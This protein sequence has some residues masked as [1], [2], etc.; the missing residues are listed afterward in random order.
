M[1]QQARSLPTESRSCQSI[2]WNW[3]DQEVQ[4][5]VVG[6]IEMALEQL[7]REQLQAAWNQRT[8]QRQGW[9]NGYRR[10]GLMTPHGVLILRVPRPRRGPFDPAVIFQRYQRR[11]TQV[12][13]VLRH[14]YLLGVST[15]DTAVLAE[16]LFGGVLSHQTISHLSRWLDG[17]LAQ[18]RQQRIAPIY[19][20]VYIDGMHVDRIGEDR[21]VLL[22]AGRRSD[23]GMDILGFCLSKGEECRTLLA[24]LRQRGLEKVQ[25]FVSD[26]SAAIRSAL[27]EVYP[28]VP[29]QHCVFHRLA[30]LRKDIGATE[31]R[32]RMLG[33]AACI[34]RCPSRLAALDAAGLWRQRWQATNPAAVDHFL[35][36]L[37]DSVNFYELPVTWWKRVRTNNPLERFI[38]TLRQRLRPM[39]CFYDDAAIERAVF[40]QLLRQHKIK[41]THKT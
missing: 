16:Q 19:P 39:G 23:G 17:Q 21:N 22:V 33:E 13:R 38:R 7:L 30:Q 9:R 32:D 12:E 41:V 2:F 6:L 15:R 18:W 29:W 4:R 31:Y 27:S 8:A 26:E 24:D 25:M 5:L 34:F 35:V 28:E 11:L 3:I 14:A 36:G 10:R 40:G 20:V 37:S 1:T